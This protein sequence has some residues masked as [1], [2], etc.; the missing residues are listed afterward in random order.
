MNF[1]KYTL[2][3]CYGTTANGNTFPIAFAILFGNEDKA[4]WN[5]FWQFALALHPTLNHFS[6]T[7]ITDQAKGL[8]ESVKE[9]LPEAGH[10][11]CSYHRK[12][13]IDKYLKGGSQMYSGKWLYEKLMRAKTRPEI[14]HIKEESAPYMS[15]KALNYLNSIEDTEQYPAARCAVQHGIYM[16]QR[17]SSSAV[18]SMNQANKPARD[19]TAVDVMQSMK[20]LLDLE[21]GRF[22]AKKQLAWGWTE[23]LTPHGI[24]L[25]DEIFSKVDFHDYHILVGDY[26]DEW[27]CRVCR[28]NRKERQVYFPK[29]PVMGSYFGGC[30][31]GIPNTDGVPCHH[32]VAVVKSG[33]IAGLTPN[34][35]MPKWWTTEMWRHQ[36]PQQ[37]QSLCDF[38]LNNIKKVVAPDLTWRYCPPYTA[39]NKSGRPKEGK[40]RKSFLEEKKPCKRKGSVKEAS[41]EWERKRS[42]V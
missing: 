9:I 26:E 6:K 18:E 21:S 25:R 33:R 36:Y 42:K 1:G 12:K 28:G 37:L 19:R 23:T 4:G 11:H 15:Q 17:S 10:F 31:C 39:P 5:I 34:N 16:Y 22:M 3:S 29:E 41:D 20:L 14:E 35:S 38:S 30:S 2:Y 32:M 13:N 27:T 24:K 7:F 8:V 40:R